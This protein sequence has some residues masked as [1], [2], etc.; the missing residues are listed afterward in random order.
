MEVLDTSSPAVTPVELREAIVR[1][2]DASLFLH[3]G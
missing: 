2:I 1:I 3:V